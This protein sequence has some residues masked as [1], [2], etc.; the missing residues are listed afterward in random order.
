M[1]AGAFN[2]ADVHEAISPAIITL[3]EAKA[4]RRVEEFH[5]TRR[6]FTR[7]LAARTLRTLGWR[8]ERKRLAFNLQI[9]RRNATI[10]INQGEGKR[11]TRSQTFKA[12]LLNSTDVHEHIFTAIIARHKAEAFIA[13]EKLYAAGAFAHDLGWHLRARTAVETAATAT[14]AEAAAITAAAAAETTASAAGTA[15]EPAAITCIAAATTA[16]RAARVTAEASAAWGIAEAASAAAIE[17]LAKLVALS[18]TTTLAAATATIPIKT[19]TPVN[20]QLP[21][22]LKA[23]STPRTG[24][25][26]PQDAGQIPDAPARHNPKAPQA[27]WKKHRRTSAC[28]DMDIARGRA[29][30]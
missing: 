17:I 18:T 30:A 5:F 28:P 22:R 21:V 12:S 11:L 9:N 2:C 27:R 7:Q 6:A 16:A 3:E 29:R 14:A 23:N 26:M 13:V 20:T 15:A 1:H 25:C 24:V 19:H 4:L 10:T 8:V